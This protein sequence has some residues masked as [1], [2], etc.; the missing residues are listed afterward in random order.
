MCESFYKTN[1][2]SHVHKDMTNIAVRVH[3][4]A[5]I[6]GPRCTRGP[7]DYAA[8]MPAHGTYTARTG[9]DHGIRTSS[10][11]SLN[12]NGIRMIEQSKLNQNSACV[13]FND[14]LAI[15]DDTNV[16]LRI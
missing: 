2:E 8:R 15:L 9:L 14:S 1:I 11:F 5:V 10:S 4:S 3:A 6:C 16:A 12:K 7:A 13:S